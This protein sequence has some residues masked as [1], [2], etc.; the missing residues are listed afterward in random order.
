MAAQL[1]LRN[2]ASDLGGA[3]QKSLSTTRGAASTTAI[4]T[5]TVSGTNIQVTQT[6]GGQALTW[7]SDPVPAHSISGTVTV[8]IRGLESSTAVNAGAGIL[9]ERTNGAGV[10]Q[11]TILSDRTVP[12]TIT[13][14]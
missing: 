7:F 2:T 12:A 1:F 10:V 6:A 3:G 14:W 8:N 4:T 9:I 5:T 11:S 13:E